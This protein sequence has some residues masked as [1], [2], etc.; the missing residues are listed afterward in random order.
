MISTEFTTMLLKTVRMLF[1]LN[2]LLHVVLNT[3]W[4]YSF[5]GDEVVRFP[6]VFF[7]LTVEGEEV[8][9]LSSASE[10]KYKLI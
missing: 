3:K 9:S 10:E 8:L 4:P 7:G 6:L 2:D 1:V 5:L